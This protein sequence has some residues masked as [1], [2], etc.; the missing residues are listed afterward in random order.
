MMLDSQRQDIAAGTLKAGDDRNADG[1][2][3]S[4]ARVG[5]SQMHGQC[6]ARRAVLR[7]ERSFACGSPSGARSLWMAMGGTAL[8]ERRGRVLMHLQL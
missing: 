8:R 1:S 7:T 3:R 4:K 5:R 6:A 2:E